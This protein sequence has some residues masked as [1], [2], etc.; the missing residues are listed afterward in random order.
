MGDPITVACSGVE[1]E[2][3]LRRRSRRAWRR[4]AGEVSRGGVADGGVRL[5]RGKHHVDCGGEEHGHTF[6]RRRG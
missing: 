5:A 2:A 6:H 4:S 3:R 1:Q